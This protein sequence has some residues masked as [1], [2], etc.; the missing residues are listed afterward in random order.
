[1]KTVIL[2]EKPSQAKKYAAAFQKATKQEKHSY[3]VEDEKLF[4]NQ[5][6]SLTWAIGHLLQPQPPEKYNEAWQKW[7]LDTLPMIPEAFVME[8]AHDKKDQY[9]AVATLLKKADHIIIATDIDREGEAIARS[10]IEKEKCGH[11]QLSR[12]WIN[13]LEADEVRKGFE[14]LQPAKKYEGM[15]KEAQTRQ[16][17][18]WLVGMNASRLYSLTIQ[19]HSGIGD[20]YSVGRVQSSLL[21]LIYNRQREIEQFQSKPFFEP[22]VDVKA[23]NGSFQA[24]Y[25]DRFDRKEDATALFQTHGLSANGQEKGVIQTLDK[26][27]KKQKAPKLFSLSGLQ[28]AMSKRYGYTPEEVKK[29]AQ[30]LY[31]KEFLSYP[32][33]DCE[34]ITK[35][36]LAYLKANRVGYQE[37]LG[38]VMDVGY[39]EGQSKHVNGDKVQEHYAIVPT[40][41][42]PT[43]TQHHQ[44]PDMEQTIYNEVLATTLAMFATDHEYE[45][46]KVTVDVKGLPFQTSGKVPTKEGWK[47]LFSFRPSKSDD[48]KEKIEPKLPILTE[49][50]RVQAS[51]RVH[52]GQTK[53]PSFY[54][55]GN[56]INLMKTCGKAVEDDDLASILS[57]T[58]GIGT[59]ATRDGIIEK[60]KKAKY[61]EIK[62]K[63]VHVTNKGRVICEAIDGTLLG[64]P[65]MTGKWEQYLRKIGDGSGSQATFLAN[66]E[67]FLRSELAKAPGRVKEKDAIAKLLQAQQTA[68]VIGTCPACKKGNIVDKKTFYACD[69]YKDGCKMSLPK[70]FL[71]KKLTENQIKTLLT[72][73]ETPKLKGF[74]SKKGNSFE[75]KLKLEDQRIKPVF[76]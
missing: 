38:H 7:S 51:V 18:D 3:N 60:I 21:M 14:Q 64:S 56:L 53:P 5:E 43:S 19:Q 30:S 52:E 58:K 72:G 13:T 28:T 24:K 36:E 47:A 50:E 32:R 49:G 17:S 54:T 20:R 4:P 57:E 40:K 46:T 42:L 74:K 22:V 9:K 63:Q 67:K 6:V 12:L 10:I 41:T 68:L 76:N 65:E 44:W 59:E 25:K 62:K 11:K 16:M 37:L 2:A 8:V 66:I 26:E 27:T 34:Y 73:K 69:R 1:M 61:I 31:D 75:A 45:E 29:A 33:T 23:E 35:N 55:E 15:Y 39:P 48:K 71:K 70:T